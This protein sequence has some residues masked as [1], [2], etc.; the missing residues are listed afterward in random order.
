[1]EDDGGPFPI[2]VGELGEAGSKDETPEAEV[3]VKEDNQQDDRG[4]AADE[5]GDEERNLIIRHDEAG[6]Y[7]VI[8]LQEVDYQQDNEH[9]HRHKRGLAMDDAQGPIAQEQPS[10]AADEEHQPEACG[11]EDIIALEL[12][13][14]V[15]CA[16]LRQF[17]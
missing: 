12:R 7:G 4:C 6:R 14:V 1:M 3:Q 10:Y 5:R 13:E 11:A 8:L 17:G 15:L 16:A 9:G 2:L